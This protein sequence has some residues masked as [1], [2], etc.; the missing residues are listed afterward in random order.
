[1]SFAQYIFQHENPTAEPFRFADH[2]RFIY[3]R[4]VIDQLGPNVLGKNLTRSGVSF[5]V[6][7]V[8]RGSLI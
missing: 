5:H 3:K 4:P 1:M 6:S 2:G 8:N 7:S